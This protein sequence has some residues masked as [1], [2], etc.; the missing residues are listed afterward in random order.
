MTTPGST[1]EAPPRADAALLSPLTAQLLPLVVLFFALLTSSAP[2]AHHVMGARELRESGSTT[3][4]RLSEV[5]SREAEARP[6]LWRYDSI[7]LLAHLGTY[8]EEPHVVHLSVVDLDGAP[9]GNGPAPPSDGVTWC[10]A[11][12]VVRGRPIGAVWVGM[13]LAGLRERSL[14]LLGVFGSLS[15]LLSAL[16][17]GVSTRSARRAET[18]IDALVDRLSVTR[19]EA[20]IRTLQREA[21]ARQDEERRAIARDLHDTVGQTLTAIRIQAQLI[22]GDA[23]SSASDRKR[24]ETIAMTTDA[25]IEDVRRALDRLRPAMLDE[26]G[27]LPALQRLVDDAGERGD[28]VSTAELPEVLDVPT[29]VGTA[30]FRIVQESLT[31]VVRHARASSVEV[32]IERVDGLVRMRIRD[33]G[34]GPASAEASAGRGLGFARERAEI[35]GGR[36]EVRTRERGGTEIYVELPASSD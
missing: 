30:I 24:G 15:A 8:R 20:R 36:F 1:N 17:Y 5:I 25:T 18:R 2:V 6:V 23:S 28:L 27:L 3:A 13:S 22:A 7:R 33:D 35:L 14:V 21:L 19:A 29:A 12:I 32:A 26:I 4:Q 11:P 34:R 16:V 10:T 31:N 9:I